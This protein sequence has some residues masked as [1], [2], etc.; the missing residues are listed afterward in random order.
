MK[1][2]KNSS[3]APLTPAVIGSTPYS[4]TGIASPVHLTLAGVLYKTEFLL[5]YLFHCTYRV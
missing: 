2:N 5:F 1:N 4:L 3:E